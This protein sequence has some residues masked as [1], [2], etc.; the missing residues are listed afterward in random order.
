M[1]GTG[2]QVVIKK[3]VIDSATA[4]VTLE[5]PLQNYYSNSTVSFIVYLKQKAFGLLKHLILSA[6]VAAQAVSKHVMI[7]FQSLLTDFKCP[8][9]IIYVGEVNSASIIRLA[10]RPVSEEETLDEF[11]ATQPQP[12]SAILQ[13]SLK[14]LYTFELPVV[15]RY[16]T[17]PQYEMMRSI[18]LNN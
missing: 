6:Q 18:L 11:C 4:K 15:K 14:E 5:Y 17:L 7:V 12:I 2:H 13:H 3:A 8:K 1:Y 9:P 16:L 10:S